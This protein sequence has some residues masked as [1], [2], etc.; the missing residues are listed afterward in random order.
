MEV[1]GSIPCLDAF[2]PYHCSVLKLGLFLKVIGQKQKQKKL[3]NNDLGVCE[4]F[5]MR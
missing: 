4:C 2:V 1:T 3:K 5:E